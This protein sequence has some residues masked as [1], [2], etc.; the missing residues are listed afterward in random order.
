V[1]H[2]TLAGHLYFE[3]SDA[4]AAVDHYREAIELIAAGA[5]LPG[6][7]LGTMMIARA[8]HV[9]GRAEEFAAIEYQFDGLILPGPHMR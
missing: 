5:R 7:G 2:R 4:D 8:F 9:A 1:R 3:I 6:F